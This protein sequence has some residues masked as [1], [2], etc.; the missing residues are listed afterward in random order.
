MS[1]LEQLATEVQARH[2]LRLDGPESIPMVPRPFQP[3]PRPRTEI[4]AQA[5]K[6]RIAARQTASTVSDWLLGKARP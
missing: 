1:D 6:R 5:A 4:I 3:R 2:A